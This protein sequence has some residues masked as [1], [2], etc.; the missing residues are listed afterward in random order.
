MQA[1]SKDVLNDKFEKIKAPA[2]QAGQNAYEIIALYVH[3]AIKNTNV[4]TAIIEGLQKFIFRFG[5]RTDELKKQKK[6]THEIW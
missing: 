1:A 6:N 3:T 5:K 4:K 2:R